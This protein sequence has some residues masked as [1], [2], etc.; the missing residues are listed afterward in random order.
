MKNPQV[1]IDL[2]RHPGWKQGI[3]PR[4]D[5]KTIDI[6]HY[7]P[8][9]YHQNRT[10]PELIYFNENENFADLFTKGIPR[11]QKGTVNKAWEN[12]GWRKKYEE[13]SAKNEGAKRKRSIA[14]KAKGIRQILLSDP[15]FQGLVVRS[16]FNEFTNLKN[17][18]KKLVD[19]EKAIE[20]VEVIE[21]KL[22]KSKET[23]KEKASGQKLKINSRP[24]KSKTEKR[25]AQDQSHEKPKK[26]KKVKKDNR[27]LN[28][29]SENQ[30][31]TMKHFVKIEDVNN[32]ISNLEENKKPTRRSSM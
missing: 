1:I 12:Q 2:P 9:N 19:H 18:L 10:M 8:T 6:Y 23:N 13:N 7:D 28:D 11:K 30:Y 5:G 24:K 29:V 16:D 31:E 26:V 22:A 3:S 15:D 27:T 21:S 4:E 17:S 25:P 20:I 14:G 32:Y